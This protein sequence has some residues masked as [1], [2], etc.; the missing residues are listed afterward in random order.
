[1]YAVL[2]AALGWL[3]RAVVVKAVVLAAVLALLVIVVPMAVTQLTPLISTST[4]TTVWG[5]IP[6]G[7]WY[8]V[9]YLRLDMGVPLVISAW[10]A[11]FLIRRIPMIG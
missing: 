1:M 3:I 4:L 10:V 5:A 8:G 2:T 11:R 9:D 6:P 7:V